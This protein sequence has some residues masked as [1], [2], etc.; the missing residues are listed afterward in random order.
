MGVGAH[1]AGLLTLG[2]PARTTCFG[3]DLFSS[4]I[5]RSSG[6][7][8]LFDCSSRLLWGTLWHRVSAFWRHLGQ[9]GNRSSECAGIG[10]QRS[11]RQYGTGA[12]WSGGIGQAWPESTTGRD[13][14]ALRLS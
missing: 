2:V 7:S 4:C 5:L 8:N 13:A 1:L 6:T 9:A 12:R 10:S 3:T 11:R 14:T